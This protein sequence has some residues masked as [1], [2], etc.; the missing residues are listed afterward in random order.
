[1]RIDSW[2]GGVLGAALC[3]VLLSAEPAQRCQQSDLPPNIVIPH[4]LTRVLQSIYDRSPTFRAQCER[5]AQARDLRVTVHLNNAIP[6][7]CRAFTRI[8]RQ[9]R[10]IRAEVHLPPGS[11]LV[12][13]AGHEFEHLI[14]QV[15]G[16]DLRSMAR[17]RR[18][19][20]RE[21]YPEAF[22][23]DRAIIAGRIVRAEE[24]RA[25]ESPAD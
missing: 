16:L 19:G 20:V 3:G 21:V 4:M 5:L 14:E 17:A 1:M 23:S 12:E 7:R 18:T 13:L 6:S 8:R 9:G 2:A 10:E 22:E 25:S 15:E 11:G 24:R